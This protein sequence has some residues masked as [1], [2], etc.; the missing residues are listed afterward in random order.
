VTTKIERSAV[1]VWATQD[2]ASFTPL[3]AWLDLLNVANSEGIVTI[4]PYQERW[5]WK[6]TEVADFFT[7]LQRRGHLRAHDKTHWCITFQSQGDGHLER[8]FE[9]IW[10]I[11]PLKIARKK[12]YHAY[13]ATRKGRKGVKPVSA[14]R[15][16]KATVSYVV[17]RKDESDEFTMHAST[18]FGP[19]NRWKEKPRTNSKPKGKPQWARPTSR[20][21]T[22]GPQTGTTNSQSR[23]KTPPTPRKKS[24]RKKSPRKSDPLSDL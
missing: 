9:A 13:C 2:T 1:E 15:L 3:E 10:K 4:L 17:A 23:K 21:L 14:R 12:G 6:G 5:D 20:D 7:T 8:E 22:K 16:M 18:F 11:Y 19:D 24:P